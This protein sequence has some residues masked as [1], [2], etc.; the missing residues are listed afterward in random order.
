MHTYFLYNL[1]KAHYPPIMNVPSFKIAFIIFLI[2]KMTLN[3]S[4]KILTVNIM[5]FPN[6]PEYATKIFNVELIYLERSQ[7]LG[8]YITK[9]P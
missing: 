3:R 7:N 4:E 2:I 1:C 8:M 6:S 9:E 5:L